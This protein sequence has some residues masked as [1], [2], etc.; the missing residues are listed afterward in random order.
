MEVTGC[1]FPCG[2]WM[3]AFQTVRNFQTSGNIWRSPG[4]AFPGGALMFAFPDSLEFPDGWKHLE[5]P[6]VSIPGGGHWVRVPGWSFDVCIPRQSGIP[7]RVETSGISI[8]LHSRWS[9]DVCIPR[10]SGIFRL[11]GMFICLHSGWRTLSA[12]SRAML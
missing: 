6:F 8:C 2:T 11:S 9:F 7:S 12:C 3:Y 1:A 5:S 4:R 10:Q